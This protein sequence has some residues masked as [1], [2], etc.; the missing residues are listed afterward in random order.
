ML[1][2]EIDKANDLTKKTRHVSYI[3]N[4]HE[5]PQRFKDI[6]QA[7]KLRAFL[8]LSMNDGR[9]RYPTVIH[10][11]MSSNVIDDLLSNFRCLRVLSLSGYLNNIDFPE[12]IGNF[13][14]LIYVI[15]TYQEVN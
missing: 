12:S 5:T 9:L 11:L 2:I 3:R 14:H 13:K 6:Y 1:P 4:S 15:W 10:R 7:S 8:P